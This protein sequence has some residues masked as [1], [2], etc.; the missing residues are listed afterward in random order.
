M[1]KS[2]IISA[3]TNTP[4]GHNGTFEGIMKSNLFYTKYFWGVPVISGLL[5]MA[6]ASSS[7]G[8]DAARS[9]NLSTTL[10]LGGVFAATL[11]ISL[12]GSYV[13]SFFSNLAE[14]A[15]DEG[16]KLTLFKSG[17]AYTIPISQ[18]SKV[19]FGFCFFVNLG[20]RFFPSI[21]DLASAVISLLVNRYELVLP[22]ITLTLATPC[23]LGKTISFSPAYPAEK[24]GSFGI[25]PPPIFHELEKRIRTTDAGHD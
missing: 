10:L 14:V 17:A 12:Y 13:R 21:S 2:L 11:L 7:R 24:M 20:G 15:Y 19:E 16:D 5:F 6:L 8:H 9:D 22:K 25:Q 4:V 3:G 23:S 1:I 18:I